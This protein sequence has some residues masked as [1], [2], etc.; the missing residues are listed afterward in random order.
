V[1][2]GKVK[3]A[4]ISAA[5]HKATQYRVDQLFA[6][7]HTDIPGAGLH[8]GCYHFLAYDVPIAQQVQLYTSTIGTPGCFGWVIDFERY[9]GMLPTAA[10][11]STLLSLLPPDPV[12]LYGNK[13]D[14]ATLGTAFNGRVKVWLA[15]YSLNDGQPHGDPAAIRA[16]TQFPPGD[17]ILWQYTSKGTVDGISG[18][19]DVSMWLGTDAEWAAYTGESV[20]ITPAQPYPTEEEAVSM[21]KATDPKNGCHAL[22]DVVT[23]AVYCYNPNWTP[24]GHY[25]GGGNR[26]GWVLGGQNGPV[27]AFEFFDDGNPDHSAYVMMTQA[28]DGTPHPFSFPSSGVLAK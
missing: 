27:V 12:L 19:V 16:S 25:L 3:A 9:Q 26:Q 20:P 10:Q 11:L 21:L 4:G 2:W 22:C 17:V 24:G 15:N 14:L 18:Y 1:D 7:H 5:I 6:R 13:G 28:P 23:G 8:H